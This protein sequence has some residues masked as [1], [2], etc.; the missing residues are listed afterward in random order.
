PTRRFCS[1]FLLHSPIRRT[2][3]FHHATTTSDRMRPLAERPGRSRA[4][5][6]PNSRAGVKRGQGRLPVWLRD[7]EQIMAQV[8]ARTLGTEP[9]KARGEKALPKDKEQRLTPAKPR[10][11]F[12]R[13]VGP[14]PRPIPTNFHQVHPHNRH[15]RQSVQKS[16]P[17][18]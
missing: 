8:R 13:G 2:V 9:A 15:N 1:W 5:I 6:V 17:S 3:G 16:L 4:D 18:A 11:G 10:G 7:S 12:Q 14:D